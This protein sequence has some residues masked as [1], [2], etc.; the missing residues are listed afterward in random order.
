MSKTIMLVFLSTETWD[1][2]ICMDMT[3][4]TKRF[5]SSN[6]ENEGVTHISI[7]IQFSVHDMT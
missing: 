7:D 1:K 3:K 5:T 6:K 2:V 4:R